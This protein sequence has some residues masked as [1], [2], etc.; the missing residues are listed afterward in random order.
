M[1]KEGRQQRVEGLDF[2]IV[3]ES[4]EFEE[5]SEYWRKQCAILYTN[6]FKEL[7]TGS[8][9]LLKSERGEGEKA[10]LLTI[11]SILVASGITAKAFDRIFD[12]INLWLIS[13]PT[14]NVILKNPDGSII[15]EFSKLSKSE[16]LKLMEEYH[17][18]ITN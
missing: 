1:Q 15:G 4:E 2:H 13:R 8:V 5:S 17:F 11:F 3:L 18:S 16:A 6:I 12:I 7:P 14:A 10:E 9:E